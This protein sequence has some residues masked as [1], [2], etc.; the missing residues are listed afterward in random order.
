MIQ[1]ITISIV[2][3]LVW[4]I[5]K[6][7]VCH[8]MPWRHRT[9]EGQSTQSP[10]LFQPGNLSHEA[11]AQE[12]GKSSSLVPQRAEQAR[13]YSA[14]NSICH[15]LFP[16]LGKSGRSNGGLGLKLV[17]WLTGFC[18]AF[19]PFKNVFFKSYG[20]HRFMQSAILIF[21]KLE[22]FLFRLYAGGDPTLEGQSTQSPLLF[23]LGSFSHRLGTIKRQ[24]PRAW[25]REE[26]DRLGSLPR[27]I[28]F[29][30]LFFPMLG[31]SG[32]SNGGLGLK[33]LQ[34]FDSLGSWD[35]LYAKG[36]CDML[37]RHPELPLF[38][39]RAGGWV[40]NTTEHEVSS[41]RLLAALSLSEL[42]LERL[43]R[44]NVLRT[45][46]LFCLAL[47][48]NVA[49][50]AQQANKPIAPLMVGDKL[51]ETFW[52]QEHRFL[53]KG[54]IVTATL[55]RFKGKVMLIDFWA[56]WCSS[57]RTAIPLIDSLSS[58]F[59]GDLV[60]V[61]VVTASN[62]DKISQIDQALKDVLGEK[63]LSSIPTIVED[64][65]LEAVLPYKY[66]STS[67]LIGRHGR[68]SGFIHHD[69]LTAETIKQLIDHTQPPRKRN[70]KVK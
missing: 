17:Q 65:Y 20:F 3:G 66:L 42:R 26:R 2:R 47:A 57:C 41:H 67:V 9:L 4:P 35:N 33:L 52:K 37:S 39:E 54:K 31:K 15:S 40:N 30:V 36:F 5:K 22:G 29:A 10:L 43:L 64:K 56:S 19:N 28:P 51:P 45:A 7:F 60:V 27:T 32:R 53:N 59:K 14:R 50:Q 38:K 25:S 70:E 58:R 1:K 8:S 62:Q 13:L 48:S 68:I 61:P 11:F 6:D 21:S 34:W 23:H 69:L 63:Y 18:S 55:E 46:V 44:K 49:V 16:L 24:N 12:N